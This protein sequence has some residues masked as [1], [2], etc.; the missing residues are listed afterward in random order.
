MKLVINKSR[1][2]LSSN[3]NPTTSQTLRQCSYCNGRDMISSSVDDLWIDSQSSYVQFNTA[4]KPGP[5]HG[6]PKMPSYPPSRYVIQ[7]KTSQ[8]AFWYSTCNR[9]FPRLRFVFTS[10]LTA[11]DI[12]HRGS[13]FQI[14]TS[15]CSRRRRLYDQS[16]A[17]ESQR[18]RFFFFYFIA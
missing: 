1:P 16:T 6:V 11:T 5:E 3:K 15:R 10:Q 18:S 9:K 2:L 4:W 13:Q 14:H 12:H 8:S 17:W 7:S